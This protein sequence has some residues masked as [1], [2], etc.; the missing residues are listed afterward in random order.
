MPTD[1]VIAVAVEAERLGYDYCMVADEGFHPDVYACLG[2]IARETE[3][4]TLGVMTN[5]YT[6]HPAV[7]ATALATVNDL[8]GGRV[9]VTMLAGGSMVLHPMGIERRRPYR[10]VADTVEAMR[11]LWSGDEVSWRGETCSLDRAR[12]GPG[13][14][15]IPVWIASRGPKLLGLAGRSADGVVF[16]VKPDLGA[17][18]ELVDDAAGAAGRRPPAR[19]YLGRICYTPELLEGQR[20]TLSFVLMDSPRRVLHSL[21]LDDH[22]A[23]IVEAASRAN[24]PELVDPLVSDELLRRYQVAGTPEECAV[25]VATLA[26]QH[27][28]DAVLIDALS[29]DLDE[30][31]AVIGDSL[32]IITGSRQ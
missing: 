31:M 21:G 30:N 13:P 22:D 26:R 27:G 2:V 8:S 29:A 3:R 17:A 23:D 16:T 12:L 14:Q 18:I 5:G 10:V 4:I 19:M 11:R 28:L 7:T 25:E 20:R 15:T 9:V 1:D 32:P 24:D 6:R